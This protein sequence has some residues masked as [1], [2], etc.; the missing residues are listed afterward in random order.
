[1]GLFKKTIKTQNAEAEKILK[2]VIIVLGQCTQIYLEGTAHIKELYKII[3]GTATLSQNINDISPTDKNAS[4]TEKLETATENLKSMSS[5]ILREV[6]A[7]RNENSIIAGVNAIKIIMDLQNIIDRELNGKSITE[8]YFNAIN[9]DTE[10]SKEQM[11]NFIEILF[12]CY[13]TKEASSYLN[14]NGFLIDENG[15]LL[16]EDYV[17]KLNI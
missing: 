6:I 11:E 1:M 10:F 16:E 17:K 8:E 15:K 4:T 5:D 13:K 14:S 2:N 3:S 9:T 7:K 12:K